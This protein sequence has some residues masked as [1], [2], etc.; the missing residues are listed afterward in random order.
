MDINFNT[1]K[2]IQWQK[3]DKQTLEVECGNIVFTVA[4]IDTNRHW[5]EIKKR[6]DAGT[7]TIK[8]AD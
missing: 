1:I 8:D 6:V 7:L 4:P 2:R 3:D 5:V